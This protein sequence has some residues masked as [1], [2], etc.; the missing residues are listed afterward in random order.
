MRALY[1]AILKGSLCTSRSDL[2]AFRSKEVCN[3]RVVIEFTTLIHV[4]IFV[5][6]VFTGGILGEKEIKPFEWRG[7][8]SSCIT[9]FHSCEVICN[10]D[11]AG[12][13]IDTFIVFSSGRSI[14]RCLTS[15]REVYRESLVSNSGSSGRRMPR[16]SLS[17]FGLDTGRTDRSNI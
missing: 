3:S 15:E 2:V 5:L 14:V 16:R 11:P 9:I 4:Y 17:L 10:E 7:F 8:G 6:A 13:T 12:F 1:R